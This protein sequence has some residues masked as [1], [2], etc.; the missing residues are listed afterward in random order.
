MAPHVE[1]LA[2]EQ[3]LERTNA[4]AQNLGLTLGEASNRL[5]QGDFGDQIVA[6]ELHIL[7]FLLDEPEYRAL[8]S[9]RGL[10]EGAESAGVLRH[11]YARG[12]SLLMAE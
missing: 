5:D 6:S 3:V 10:I 2:R 12:P 11:G 1:Q 4:L 8:W 7:R 9:R